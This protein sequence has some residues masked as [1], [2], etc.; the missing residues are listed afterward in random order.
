MKLIEIINQIYK[1]TPLIAGAIYTLDSKHLES[2]LFEIKS[3]QEFLECNVKIA[4]SPIVE[5]DK[6]YQV[7]TFRINHQNTSNLLFGKGVFYLYQINTMDFVNYDIRG[8]FL[9]VSNLDTLAE[10]VVKQG[11]EITFGEKDI[12]TDNVQEEKK[13]LANM[14]ADETNFDEVLKARTTS[15]YHEP[16]NLEKDL[17]KY[18]FLKDY[19]K[20]EAPKEKDSYTNLVDEI[21]SFEN[22]LN[23]CDGLDDDQIITL[24][25]KIKNFEAKLK[26]KVKPK[27]ITI[28]SSVHNKIKKFCSDFNL[29]I[30]DWVEETLLNALDCTEKYSD[31]IKTKYKTREEWIEAS[32]EE[33][34][35]KWRE[36][37]NA[38][39]TKLIKAE[40]YILKP[41]FIFKGM[42]ML[43]H[44]PMYDYIG[45]DKE[46][47]NDLQSIKCKIFL[48]TNKA[49]IN[50][51]YLDQFADIPVEGFDVN[52]PEEK[53]KD[54]Y[55]SDSEFVKLYGIKPIQ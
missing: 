26:D 6:L 33:L 53:L 43:D 3:C 49:E 47:E 34:L 36:Y 35:K 29:R 32:S 7:H 15:T 25:D 41:K 13:Q 27:T 22:I 20:K 11:I 5:L 55:L 21:T 30:G 12:N 23:N 51:S 42:S 1:G 46:F 39:I 4:H 18:P 9:P 40:Y 54:K 24:K 38:K 19:L 44:K 8:F 10:K 50:K 37:E 48:T 14:L 45:T 28:S 17:E 31:G 52:T 2:H 16:I